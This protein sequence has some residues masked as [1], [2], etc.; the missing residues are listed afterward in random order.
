[1]NVSVDV[2]IVP[3]AGCFFFKSFLAIRFQAKIDRLHFFFSKNIHDPLS[4]DLSNLDIKYVY[5]Y[6]HSVIETLPFIIAA[7][8]TH[9]RGQEI[10]RHTY[11]RD[12]YCTEPLRRWVAGLSECAPGERA[13]DFNP[14]VCVC[15][16]VSAGLVQQRQMRVYWVENNNGQVKENGGWG[17]RQKKIRYI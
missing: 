6:I 7:H 17:L 1:V 14:N 3:W 13:I 15:V 4:S 8:H 10:N 5:T 16:C 11:G 9:T 2:C 12:Y